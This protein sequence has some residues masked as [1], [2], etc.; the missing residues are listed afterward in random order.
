MAGRQPV[1]GPPSAPLFLRSRALKAYVSANIYFSELLKIFPFGIRRNHYFLP[2]FSIFEE[3][4]Q[5]Y[6]LLGEV[7]LN[8]FPCT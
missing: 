3:K 6:V 1:P 8:I 5:T 2:G 4:C 7:S